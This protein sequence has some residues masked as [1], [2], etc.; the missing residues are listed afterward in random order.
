MAEA[1]KL[2]RLV[3]KLDADEH[4]FAGKRE[5]V[6]VL[7][8]IERYLARGIGGIGQLDLG[9]AGGATD[10]EDE[11]RAE[12]VGRTEKVAG[13]CRSTNSFGFFTA[14]SARHFQFLRALD[15]LCG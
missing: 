14:P 7:E 10:G 9:A 11:G 3:E 13:V 1:G 2:D 15:D 5:R 8:V 12:G 4:A 6:G